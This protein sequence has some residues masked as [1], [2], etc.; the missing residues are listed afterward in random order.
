MSEDDWQELLNN[1]LIESA[2]TEAALAGV[3]AMIDRMRDEEEEDRIIRLSRGI[4]EHVRKE[5]EINIRYKQRLAALEAEFKA[6]REVCLEQTFKKFN[7]GEF[8]TDEPEAQ[9]IWDEM[10]R[11]ARTLMRDSVMAD[12]LNSSSGGFT[13]LGALSQDLKDKLEELRQEE[14]EEKD[15][16]S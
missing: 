12:Q 11:A 6:E 7:N 8:K 14:R 9:G 10:S 5:A 15:R 4:R 1:E 2:F 16:A 13:F 3:Q